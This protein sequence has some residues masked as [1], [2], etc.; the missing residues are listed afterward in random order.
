MEKCEAVGEDGHDSVSL[1]CND[2]Q[3]DDSSTWASGLRR[4]A[5]LCKSLHNLE[6]KTRDPTPYLLA[7]RMRKSYY[8]KCTKF[9]SRISQAFFNRSPP[10]FAG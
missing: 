5:H 10:N 2:E 3:S 4:R 6:H 7:S 1:G 9:Q 8:N